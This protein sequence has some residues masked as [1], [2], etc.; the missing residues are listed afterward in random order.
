MKS[1]S[2]KERTPVVRRDQKTSSPV[3]LSYRTQPAT[4]VL[5]PLA[6]AAAAEMLPEVMTMMVLT[7]MMV[8]TVVVMNNKKHSCPLQYFDWLRVGLRWIG[9]DR[10]GLS[11][12]Q[13]AACS[14]QTMNTRLV[15]VA[16]D[17][18]SSIGTHPSVVTVAVTFVPCLPSLDALGRRCRSRNHRRHLLLYLLP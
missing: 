7:T 9:S 13:A 10:D 12:C 1:P 11:R 4:F 8:K 6:A 3:R 14:I 16:T 15:R 18:I 17:W 5:Y 2:G